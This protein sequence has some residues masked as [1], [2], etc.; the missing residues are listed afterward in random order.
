MPFPTKTAL[1]I[2]G[3]G[4]LVV[5][6]FVLFGPESPPAGPVGGMEP[7]AS[8]PVASAPAGPLLN[9]RRPDGSVLSVMGPDCYADTRGNDVL[10]HPS[11]QTQTD[12]FVLNKGGADL[13]DIS[14]KTA[15]EPVYVHVVGQPSASQTVVL[16]AGDNVVVADGPVRLRLSGAAGQN[17]ILSLPNLSTVDINFRQRGDDV[18]IAIPGGEITIARQSGNTGSGIVSQIMLQGGMVLER[19][20]IRVQS[21]VGQGTPG[22]DVIRDTDSDDVIYPGLGDDT[23]TLLGGRNRIHYEGGNDRINSAGDRPSHN[24][25]FVPFS[26][27]E[28]SVRRSEDGRDVVLVVP[29][30]T[31]RLDLQ[32]F[33]PVGDPRNPIQSVV[34]LDG[35]VDEA[36]IRQAAL[37]FQ[38]TEIAPET[39][40]RSRVRN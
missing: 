29:S 38:D 4:A 15:D 30:G 34:F 32:M 7:V 14:R 17:T 37:D 21:V 23:I 31:I 20:Q 5:T 11:A 9:F 6:G 13:L 35:P 36:F 24:T 28:V 10:L 39:L 8:A 1:G 19:S 40:D 22:N 18:A 26:R 12:C 3:V 33:Y 25:L 2:L 16:G 27:S